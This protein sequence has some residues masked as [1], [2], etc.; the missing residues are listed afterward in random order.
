M[1]TNR[2]ALESTARKTEDDYSGLASYP[3]A[4][5]IVFS[6][7]ERKSGRLKVAMYR[8]DGVFNRSVTLGERLSKDGEWCVHGV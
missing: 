4:E 8:K 3:S 7:F 1:V 5:H 2:T 6:G